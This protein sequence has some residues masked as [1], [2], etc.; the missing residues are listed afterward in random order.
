MKP[1]VLLRGL[2]AECTDRWPEEVGEHG[3]QK[4]SPVGRHPAEPQRAHQLYGEQEEEDPSQGANTLR[5][6]KEKSAESSELTSKA[7]C[8]T[9]HLAL[10]PSPGVLNICT[11]AKLIE[12]LDRVPRVARPSFCCSHSSYISVSHLFP[13]SQV[14][15]VNVSAS[16]VF[17]QQTS[18]LRSRAR[19]TDVIKVVHQGHC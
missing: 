17:P 5:T 7:L 6:E 19:V 9:L 1:C 12:S 13:G 2:A 15:D 14:A 4:C 8:L 10:A 11:C 18:C 16:I 3:G